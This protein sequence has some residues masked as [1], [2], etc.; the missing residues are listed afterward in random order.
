MNVHHATIARKKSA[1]RRVLGWIGWAALALFVALGVLLAAAF[2]YYRQRGPTEE[3]RAALELMR[4]DWRPTQGVNA[5]PALFYLHHDVPAER[6][7]A[8]LAADVER[9]RKQHPEMDAPVTLE[10]DADAPAPPPPT[11]TTDAPPLP[12]L[13]EAQQDTLCGRSSVGCLAHVAAQTDAVRAVL[14]AH[15]VSAARAQ[16]F[17]RAD[18]L[19]NPGDINLHVPIMENY[20][21][22]RQLWLSAFALRYVE[23][24]RLGALAATCRH[25]AAWRRMAPNSNWALGAVFASAGVRGASWLY[26]E[27]LADLPIDT[28]V[29]EDCAQALQPVTAAD[30]NRCAVLAGEFATLDAGMFRQLERQV[31]EGKISRSAPLLDLAQT[32]A[33]VARFFAASCDGDAIARLLADELP[34][35][36][37]T[38]LGARNPQCVANVAG[39]MTAGLVAGLKSARFDAYTLQYAAHLRLAAT[40]QW[41][42]EHSSEGTIA[43]LFER[44]PAEL[45]SPRH[46][47]GFDAARGVIYV[48]E[49]AKPG[50]K[51]KPGRFALPVA[52]AR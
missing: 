39:C 27:M 30:V 43:E 44:R 40:V 24:D 5:F 3:Q 41:L 19:W 46:V 32:E 1:A 22:A 26:A 16:D 33:Q 20:M 50:D 42:R 7:Q 15:P 6:L 29:P 21:N 14:A 36:E 13:T 52:R 48:D 28:A 9:V 38:P 10:K 51:D 25:L 34:R 17:E 49:L 8:Q 45:R 11:L 18:F 35:Q 37:P 31:S 23:G 4:K 12:E 2:A 47:S